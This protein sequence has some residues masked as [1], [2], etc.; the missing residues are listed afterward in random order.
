MEDA[1]GGSTLP[2]QFSDSC[3]LPSVTRLF[4]CV[5][6]WPKKEGRI[7]YRVATSKFSWSILARHTLA[8]VGANL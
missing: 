7:T 2:A 3:I 6:S 5:R 4:V 1:A 8:L